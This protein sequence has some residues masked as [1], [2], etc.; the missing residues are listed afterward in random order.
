MLNLASEPSAVGLQQQL[1][2]Q[3]HCSLSTTKPKNKAESKRNK[4]L[5]DGYRVW[6]NLTFKDAKTQLSS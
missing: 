1:Q 4:L 3:F 6:R 5:L 2:K